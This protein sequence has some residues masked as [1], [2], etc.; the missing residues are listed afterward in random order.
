MRFDF[1]KNLQ[2]RLAKPEYNT[3]INLDEIVKKN[4]AVFYTNIYSKAI[5]L[6]R[7]SRKRF[8]VPHHEAHA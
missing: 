2:E 5:I 4:I 6:P 7:L 1:E 8:P 3:E